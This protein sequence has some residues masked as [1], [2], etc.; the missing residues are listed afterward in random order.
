MI[1]YLFVVTREKQIEPKKI[2][3]Y[4]VLK[5]WNIIYVGVANGEDEE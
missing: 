1:V 3:A 2:K 4:N 5:I